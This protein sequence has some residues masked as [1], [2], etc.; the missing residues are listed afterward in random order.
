VSLAAGQKASRIGTVL[1]RAVADRPD[2]PLAAYAR[3]LASPA[4]DVPVGGLLT[5]SI[6]AIVRL[7]GS[8]PAAPRLA[9][10]DYKSNMLHAAGATA[11]LDAYDQPGLLDEMVSHH[12][13]LQALLYGTA[14]FR[15]L[16]WRAPASDPDD[17]IRGVVYA[18][19][20][21]MKGPATPADPLG[22]R[23]GVFTWRA[24][25]G[26]WAALSDL[27]AGRETAA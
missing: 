18:F 8:T 24:P 3:L 5:G 20:R 16:R 25:R 10:C 2:D 21:G 9:I 12:Y 6:D 13:P 23:H 1:G 27:L 22:R 26:L 7:P 14:V 15:W 4:F 11:P 17:C 19:I